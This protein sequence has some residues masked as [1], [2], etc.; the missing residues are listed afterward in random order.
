ML[1]AAAAGR[2][3]VGDVMS[4]ILAEEMGKGIQTQ[5]FLRKFAEVSVVVVI[6][7]G[8]R[9]GGFRQIALDVRALEWL[10]GLPLYPLF[11][12]RSRYIMLRRW[13]CNSS[14]CL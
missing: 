12:D 3:Y 7:V 10:P 2:T 1:R 8:A 4:R 11:R 13:R 6:V 14:M 9:R 5:A